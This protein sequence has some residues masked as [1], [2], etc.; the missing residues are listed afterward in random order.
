MESSR[1]SHAFPSLGVA[2][3]VLVVLTCWVATVRIIGNDWRVDPQYSYGMLVP[4]LI[5][6]LLLKRWEDRPAPT[7]PSRGGRTV[8]LSVMLCGALLLAVVIPLAEGNPDWRPL[9]VAASLSSITVTLALLFKSGGR[10]WLRHFCFPVVFFLIAVPWPRNFEQWL[11]SGLMSWNTSTTMEV[12]HWLGYEALR[13]G[14]LI[15]LPV[16]VLGIEEACSGIRS[17]QSGLMVALFFGE[18]FRLHP[19]RRVMLLAVALFAALAGNVLRSSLLAVVA[20]RQGIDA[21]SVW[22]DPAGLIVLVI[23]VSA[24]IACALRWKRKASFPPGMDDVGTLPAKTPIQPVAGDLWKPSMPILFSVFSVMLGSMVLTEVWFRIHDLPSDSGWEWEISRR[25]G[26][27]GVTEVPIAPGTLHMMFYPEGF[28]ERWTGSSREKAQSFILSWPPGRTALQSVR[29]HSPEVCLS[30][31]GMRMEGTL[32]D[33]EFGS[34]AGMIRLHGWLFSQHGR[35]VYVFHA[36]ME[37][38]SASPESESVD[39]SLKGRMRN[40]MLGKRN[41]G[42]RMVEVAFWNLSSEAAARDA[43]KRYFQETLTVSPTLSP[44]NN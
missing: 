25:F 44:I 36:I 37:Q 28:S 3:P 39:Q 8:G 43:L 34:P 15:I 41:R 32:A 31:I 26:V 27:P 7:P 42:Q 2:L 22:H 17:L 10:A 20:S 13:Q 5:A 16:G 4:L 24:V 29:M 11:M 9:G 6:G 23:T 14:N 18:V 38:G 33:A 12:L 19:A 35:P 21:V 1:Q 40:V 30:N